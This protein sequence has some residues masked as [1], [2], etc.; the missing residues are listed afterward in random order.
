MAAPRSMRLGRDTSVNFAL[1][2][3]L[4]RRGTEHGIALQT[5]WS[6]RPLRDS[7]GA[8][9]DDDKGGALRPERQKVRGQVEDVDASAR[10]L[11]VK[12]ITNWLT[13]RQESDGPTLQSADDARP[14]T[15]GVTPRAPGSS[16]LVLRPF[17]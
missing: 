14:H 10:T 16:I 12:D 9:R 5:I 17:F 7:G 15:S 6:P 2:S 11:M 1:R 3:I 13:L 4:L 8:E